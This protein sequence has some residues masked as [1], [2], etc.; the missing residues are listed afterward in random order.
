MSLEQSGHHD[1]N[2]STWCFSICKTVHGLWLRILSIA[3]EKEIRVLDY[4]II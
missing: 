2:F 1:V 3:L 4:T